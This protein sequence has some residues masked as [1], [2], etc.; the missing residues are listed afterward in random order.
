MVF[1]R[2]LAVRHYSIYPN[3][4]PAF[5][6]SPQRLA[7]RD[8][9]LHTRASILRPSV[10]KCKAHELSVV[11]KLAQDTNS[12]ERHVFRSSEL[13]TSLGPPFPHANVNN[14]R[15]LYGSREQRLVPRLRRWRQ[16]FH[17]R[18]RSSRHLRRGATLQAG[19]RLRPQRF[20]NDASR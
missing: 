9:T 3:C 17:G 4:I 16:A 18:S 19:I 15:R 13:T 8:E 7:V 14:S 2:L 11:R 20:V 10:D 1:A 6:L 12:V 5:F